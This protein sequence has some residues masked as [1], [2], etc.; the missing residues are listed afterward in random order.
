MPSVKPK[1][2]NPILA[3]ELKLSD[4]AQPL[5]L[6]EVTELGLHERNLQR[7][8]ITPAL[9]KGFNRKMISVNGVQDFSVNFYIIPQTKPGYTCLPES[10]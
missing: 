5:P 4:P 3:E 9:L 2:L 1:L 8:G 10:A 7:S 6:F